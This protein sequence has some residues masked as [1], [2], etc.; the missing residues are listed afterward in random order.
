MSVP[1]RPLNIVVYNTVVSIIKE[2]YLWS[3]RDG[4]S[5]ACQPFTWFSISLVL[6]ILFVVRKVC[7]L[8]VC[9]ISKCQFTKYSSSFSSLWVVAFTPPYYGITPSDELFLSAAAIVNSAPQLVDGHWGHM[10]GR[11]KLW[12]TPIAP[13]LLCRLPLPFAVRGT[14]LQHGQGVNLVP[15]KITRSLDCF[16]V[17]QKSTIPLAAF[18]PLIVLWHTQA[19][20]ISAVSVFTIASLWC[21][22]AIVALLW[23]KFISTNFVMQIILPGISHHVVLEMITIILEELAASILCLLSFVY[24]VPQKVHLW[25]WIFYY[26]STIQ[27]LAQCLPP[28]LV[29]SRAVLTIILW[30]VFI[31]V[32]FFADR[33][34]PPRT[35]S[36]PSS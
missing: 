31:I 9:W 1:L 10:R 8:P 35:L 24:L 28:G 33:Y 20:W 29:R 25:H 4:F 5:D 30:G 18:T 34:S 14:E 12:S 6:S 22:S 36:F 3:E 19:S 32:F 7:L 2:L 26:P 23:C 15:Y 11:L 21:H 27:P 17:W 13:L 16:Q